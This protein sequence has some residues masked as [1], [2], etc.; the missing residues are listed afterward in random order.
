MAELRRT[1]RVSDPAYAG[2]QKLYGDQGVVD[3]VALSGYYDLV[4]MTLNTAQVRPP[5]PGPLPLPPIAR[6]AAP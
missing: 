2:V 6:K 4:S 5:E 3:L 1:R